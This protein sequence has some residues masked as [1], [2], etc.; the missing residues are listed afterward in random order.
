MLTEAYKTTSRA[1]LPLLA[2]APLADYESID[3]FLRFQSAHHQHDKIESLAGHRV[4]LTELGRAWTDTLLHM[5]KSSYK[6]HDISPEEIHI[7]S[8]IIQRTPNEILD[9]LDAVNVCP[10]Y[11]MDLVDT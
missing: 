11:N 2:S 9:R 7:S 5:L 3:P 1:A 6:F 8:P 4:R 10:V